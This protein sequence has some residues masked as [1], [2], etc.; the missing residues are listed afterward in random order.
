M[1]VSQFSFILNI[2]SEQVL[3][4]IIKQV[5]ISIDKEKM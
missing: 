2:S 5:N 3:A 1:F 4:N